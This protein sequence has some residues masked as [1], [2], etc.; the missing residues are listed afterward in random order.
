MKELPGQVVELSGKPLQNE[1][2]ITV[3]DVKTGV[4]KMP[5]W[6]AAGP[7]F[8]QGFWFKKL[9]GLHTRLKSQL[10]DCLNQGNVPEWMVRGQMELVMKDPQKGTE[11]TTVIIAR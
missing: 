4:R 11:V 2:K 7:D 1:M 3:L 9:T 8:V 6:K 5:N 10:K